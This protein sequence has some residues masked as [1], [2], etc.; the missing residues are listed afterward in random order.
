MA[1]ALIIKFHRR[2][3]KSANHAQSRANTKDDSVYVL[4]PGRGHEWL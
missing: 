2:R 4:A 1:R 3:C